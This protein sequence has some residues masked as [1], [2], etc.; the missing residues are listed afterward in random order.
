MGWAVPPPRPNAGQASAEYVALL[1][2]VVVVM[3]GAAAVGSPPAL[4][5]KVVAVVRHGICLVA[6]GVCTPREAR[7]AGLAP[8]LLQARTDRQ[9]LGGR[10]LVVRLGRSDSLLVERRS[11]GSAAVSFADGESAGGIA[12]IGL[13]LPGGVKVGGD[14]GAGLQFTSGRTWEFPSFAAAA[15]FVRRWAPRESLGGEA[16]GL[17]RK[18]WPFGHGAP[19]MPAADATYVEG[20]AY[21]EF[22]A[23]LRGPGLRSAFAGG[24][25][26]VQLGVVA[27]R[28]L[29][30]DGSETWYD[31]VDGETAVRL[32]ALIGAVEA[33]HASTAALEVRFEHGRPVEL[34]VRAAARWQGDVELPAAAASLR[35]LAGRLSGSPSSPG[36]LGRRVEAEVSLDLT[37]PRNLRA[38]SG[39]ADVMGL[40]VPPRDWGDRLRALAERLDADGDVD[41]RVL[42]V[43]LDERDVGA[44]VALGISVGGDYRRTR[45][46]RELL[47]A[48]SRRAGGP[49]REREDCDSA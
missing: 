15:R 43:G 33:H 34:R 41:V 36:G 40:R 6:G 42:R 45:E 19:R 16:R 13:Q 39:V 44:E 18:A 9:R 21:G 26:E 29:G 35:E 24:E 2:V 28:R 11:D 23:A 12:G 1:A 17:L 30:R 10:L 7:A 3:A 8:C 32:G 25:A 47:G 31:R 14:Y 38:V 20:G 22:A 46:V 4:A 27:G 5:M 49:L 48:W 37:D